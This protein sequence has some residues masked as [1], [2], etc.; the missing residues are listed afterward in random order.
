M[1]EERSGSPMSDTAT[2][3]IPACGEFEL[4]VLDEPAIAALA[5]AG[6][7]RF[8]IRSTRGSPLVVYA[9]EEGDIRQIEHVLQRDRLADGGPRPARAERAL[10]RD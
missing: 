4:R 6:Y 1:F 9:Q 7:R 10:K 3:I 8:T 5:R 2:W